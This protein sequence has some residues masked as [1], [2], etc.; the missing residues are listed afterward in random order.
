MNSMHEHFFNFRIRYLIA[1][2]ELQNEKTKLHTSDVSRKLGISLPATSTM[3]KKL[4]QDGYVEKPSFQ[5]IALTQKGKEET[6]SYYERYQQLMAYF[7]RIP[8][9]NEDDQL[10]SSLICLGAFPQSRI[11][12]LLQYHKQLP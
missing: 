9:F 7:S 3:I 4:M 10:E 11:E 5:E 8:G 12:K 2:Y 6:K 1:I